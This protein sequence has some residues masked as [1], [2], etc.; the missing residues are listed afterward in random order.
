MDCYE[1]FDITFNKLLP[2]DI[3]TIKNKINQEISDGNFNCKLAYPD[4]FPN[5]GGKCKGTLMKLFLEKM[6]YTNMKIT[7]INSFICD[8]EWKIGYDELYSKLE[9]LNLNSTKTGN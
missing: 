6:G 4:W 1:A 7:N 5:C 9:N 2:K 8:V 3:D